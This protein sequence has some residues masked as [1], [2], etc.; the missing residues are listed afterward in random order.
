ME[1][2][3]P[4]HHVRSTSKKIQISNNQTCPAT[5][6]KK[7]REVTS[8]SAN[9]ETSNMLIEPCTAKVLQ[10]KLDDIINIEIAQG[11]VSTYFGINQGCE[12][13]LHL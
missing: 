4:S 9:Y 2:A 1:S 13:L 10:N 12:R 8:K 5:E 3:K 11:A 7:Q 6:M